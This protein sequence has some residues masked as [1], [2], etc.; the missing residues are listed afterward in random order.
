MREKQSL[1]QQLSVELG[2]QVQDETLLDTKAPG[3]AE[4]NLEQMGNADLDVTI[5]DNAAN[6]L[7]QVLQAQGCTIFD[8]TE[9]RM[10]C[11]SPSQ[12]NTH[13]YAS[14]SNAKGLSTV[15]E[16]ET[17]D[18]GAMTSERGVANGGSEA[19]D[20]GELRDILSPMPSS[21]SSFFTSR[22]RN[23]S[24]SGVTEYFVASGGG[25]THCSFTASSQPV[26]IL[27]HAGLWRNH[28]DQLPGDESRPVVAQYLSMARSSG[29]NSKAY[30][31]NRSAPKTSMWELAPPQA[32][33]YLCC[34]VAEADSQPAFLLYAYFCDAN[35]AFDKT[36]ELFVEQVGAYLI[37]SSIR[38]RVLAVDR[39]QMRFAQRI[40]HELRTPLHA[41]IGVN[42]IAKES[43][44]RSENLEGM[45]DLIDSIS[46]SAD[47]LNV[48]VD[49]M[50]DF[51]LM[52]RLCGERRM[53][54]VTKTRSDWESVCGVITSTC[55]HAF[56]LTQR[57]SKVGT[58]DAMAALSIADC[59]FSGGAEQ[60]YGSTAGDVCDTD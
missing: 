8:L 14:E 45:S 17:V 53:M 1:A 23:F 16:E 21:G 25:K 18:G 41:I 3:K 42:E 36:E 33:T 43:L 40:Q 5:F 4:R 24:A 52:E 19:N 28:F 29:L 10:S 38:S 39:A 12:S 51:S 20:A 50:V 26:R 35:V 11:D 13:S 37:Y 6:Y 54:E 27:G 31:E 60:Q 48:L 9:F 59:S 55:L 49:D 30:M 58:E 7:C 2:R 22:S 57:L 46:I 34:S 15:G 32:H 56:R 47:A 44:R